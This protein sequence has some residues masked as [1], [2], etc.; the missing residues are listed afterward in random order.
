VTQKPTRPIMRYHGGKWR[1]AP[2]IISH[3]PQHRVYVEAFGGSGSLLLRKPR[4]YAEVYND[5]DG[6]IVNV[7]RVLRDRESAEE[8]VR[9]LTLTPFSRS[10][11]LLSYEPADDPIERARRTLVRSRLGF[12]SDSATRGSY[13]G[14]RDVCIKTERF[15]A[16]EWYSF[17]ETL[18]AVVDRLKNVTIEETTAIDVIRRYDTQETLFYL[19]PPYVLSTRSESARKR[20]RHEM[21]DDEHAKLLEIIDTIEGMAVISAFRNEIYDS[22]LASG[23]MRIDRES[24]GQQGLGGSKMNIESL[25]FTPGTYERTTLKLELGGV[26]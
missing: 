3:F 1:L 21:T 14:F 11:F 5:L 22:K 26:V 10:E 25:Y 13:T 17:P 12:S 19:D 7:F 4:S 8:L 16:N 2:W 18:H 6:E 24:A 20:Y 23:W 9:L 15:C